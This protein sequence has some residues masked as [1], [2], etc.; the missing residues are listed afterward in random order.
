MRVQST[1][2]QPAKAP[3]PLKLVT[4]EDLFDRVQDIYDSIA[5]RAFEIFE[6]RGHADGYDFDDWLRAESELLHP[7]HVDLAD[8]GDALA[9]QAEVPGFSLNELEVSV[10]PRRLT[11]SGKRQGKDERK[12]GKTIYAE[13]C[14]D[15]VLRV[16]DLPANVDPAKTTA[17]LKDGVLELVMPKTVQGKKVQVDPKLA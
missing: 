17:T 8:S 5:R 13:R 7:L 16:L 9:V 14:S 6:S 11:I 15:Q 2:L 1:G 10:E 3:A 4:T 12:S